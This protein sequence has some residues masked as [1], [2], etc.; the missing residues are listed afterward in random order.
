M[1]PTENAHMIMVNRKDSQHTNKI[2]LVTDNF[3]GQIEI[4]NKTS[5]LNHINRSV[6]SI[7]GRVNKV[8]E[9]VCNAERERERRFDHVNPSSAFASSSCCT[10][11]SLA[12]L[13]ISSYI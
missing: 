3:R 7:L 1:T 2:L 6:F 8:L 5:L 12:Y 10:R 4:E 11:V 9:V 13:S